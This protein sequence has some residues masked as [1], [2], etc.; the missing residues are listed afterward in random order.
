MAAA[1]GKSRDLGLGFPLAPEHH[2]ARLLEGVVAVDD[3]ATW[4][5]KE[6]AAM[7]LLVP[8]LP[9]RPVLTVLETRMDELHKLRVVVSHGALP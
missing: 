8:L 7:R 3:I 2:V 1:R 9:P 6:L 4:S 5:L